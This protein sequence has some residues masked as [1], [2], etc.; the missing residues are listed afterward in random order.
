M[1]RVVY[2]TPPK[3]GL[4]G[5][6]A[7]ALLKTNR[8]IYGGPDEGRAFWSKLQKELLDIAVKT[9]TFEPPILC[10]VLNL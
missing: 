9:S 5:V 3:E 7:G 4:P 10:C 8:H 2:V 6:P 1:Q